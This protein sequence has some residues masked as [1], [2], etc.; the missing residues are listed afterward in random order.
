ML[1]IGESMETVT[2]FGDL[3][4]NKNVFYGCLEYFL[5]RTH[6]GLEISTRI[7]TSHPYPHSNISHPLS[8]T[9]DI[10][11][12]DEIQTLTFLGNQPIF[13]TFVAMGKS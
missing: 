6:M 5:E 4:T 7:N 9:E 2:C 12:H 1:V 10:G 11:S 13:I 8:Q 3:T